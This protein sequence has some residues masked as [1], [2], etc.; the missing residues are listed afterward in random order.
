MGKGRVMSENQ[1][2]W[3]EGD[4]VLIDGRLGRIIARS[5]SGRE[6]EYLVWGRDL[7][8]YTATEDRFSDPVGAAVRISKTV[9]EDEDDTRNQLWMEGLKD[10]LRNLQG[11]IITVDPVGW[12]PLCV[13][14]E[15]HD[16]TTGDAPTLWM[17]IYEIELV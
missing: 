11:K 1:R 14:V 7:L 17:S 4:V 16:E 2:R 9:I 6:G 10:D 8:P 13:E 15:W 3:H 12:T 5:V